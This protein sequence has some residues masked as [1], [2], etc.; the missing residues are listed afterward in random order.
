[1]ESCWSSL[2]VIIRKQ[3]GQVNLKLSQLVSIVVMWKVVQIDTWKQ[4]PDITIGPGALLLR[5]TVLSSSPLWHV[6]IMLTWNYFMTMTSSSFLSRQSG[7]LLKDLTVF[8][9]DSKIPGLPLLLFIKFCSEGVDIPPV[10]RT[11]ETLTTHDPP[12]QT[13]LNWPLPLGQNNVCCHPPLDNSGTALAGK[14][15]AGGGCFQAPRGQNLE[16][17]WFPELT[18]RKCTVAWVWA[19]SKYFISHF[20]G[21]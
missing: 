13:H 17:H 7:G 4:L 16:L 21:R 1:M 8:K 14:S 3:L 12:G 11:S 18:G 15:S 20:R 5:N 2:H 19:Y 10:P 6:G 9:I